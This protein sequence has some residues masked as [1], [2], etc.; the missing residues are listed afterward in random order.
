MPAIYQLKI[1]ISGSQPPI[2]RR[3]RV[4]GDATFSE[5]HDIARIVFEGDADNE[6]EFVVNK[7][8]IYDFGPE[9]DMG[10]NPEKRDS[11]DTTLDE[12]L[13]IIKTKFTY[14]YGNDEKL[15]H[16]ITLEDIFS[17]DENLQLPVCVD[18]ERAC[19]PEGLGISVYQTILQVLS[20]TNH[21]QYKASRQLLGKKWNPEYFDIKKVN[22]RLLQY[23]HDWEEIYNDVDDIMDDEIDVFAPEDDD[24]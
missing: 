1:E 5:L 4:A 12:Y 3:I 16:V 22:K 20:D 10:D 9:L 21:P 8:R 19:P 24:D 7:L 11:M 2:W 14:A 13:N 15:E 23:A 6:Y 17:D 18:G